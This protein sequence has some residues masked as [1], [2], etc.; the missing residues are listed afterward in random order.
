[1][2]KFIQS[3]QCVSEKGYGKNR[4]RENQDASNFRHYSKG[5]SI[6]VKKERKKKKSINLK[7]VY[8]LE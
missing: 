3:N 2:F 7:I 4:K 1:M 5:W 8:I 6:R